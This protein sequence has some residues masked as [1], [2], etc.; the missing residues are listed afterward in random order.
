MGYLDKYNIDA[1][2]LNMDGNITFEK[3]ILP[4]KYG[5]I[6]NNDGVTYTWYNYFSNA[7]YNDNP[8][9]FQKFESLTEK[10]IK[11]V[12]RPILQDSSIDKREYH[13]LD[14]FKI[15][16]FNTLKLGQRQFNSW[17]D[18]NNIPITYTV[19]NAKFN[20]YNI[21][22]IDDE[23]EVLHNKEPV[24]VMIFQLILLLIQCAQI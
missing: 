20:N 9:I 15:A 3:I 8:Y 5:D 22:D 2:K 1:R 21:A 14:N 11:P 13:I 19:G 4:I 18:N 12:N 7:E 23:I 17:S 10:P 6:I 16:N 24:F